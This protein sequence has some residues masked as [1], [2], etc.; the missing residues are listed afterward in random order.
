MN[1]QSPSSQQPGAPPEPIVP[2]K[3][4]VP[5]SPPS[6]SGLTQ[7]RYPPAQ[8]S[9][10][11]PS[12]QSSLSEGPDDQ[13]S[14]RNAVLSTAQR[15]KLTGYTEEQARRS[16]K[17]EGYSDEEINTAM[18]QAYPESVH[19]GGDPSG[20]ELRY[21]FVA[22][23]KE[24]LLHPTT[25]FEVV[26]EEEGYKPVI[27]YLAILGAII[28]L[29][30]IAVQAIT[31]S[32]GIV[33]NPGGIYTNISPETEVGTAGYICMAGMIPI[34]IGLLIGIS[35]VMSGIFHLSSLVFGAR[36]PFLQTY[37][38][39]VY[40]QTPSMIFS[41]LSSVLNFE[42]L[43]IFFSIWGYILMV[44]GLKSLQGLSTG[45]AIGTILIPVVLIGGCIFAATL[46][47][48]GSVVG[49]LGVLGM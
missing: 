31:E 19:S 49:A 23:L 42:F 28:V 16:L 44:I 46:L 2:S 34:V 25:F 47:M 15:K 3:A 18:G 38:A 48:F 27:M 39:I 26:K 17:E 29:L 9:S 13:G 6:S 8:I 33:I 20:G 5:L 10:R 12:T 22:K 11:Q 37:K 14:R 21:G 4:D 43:G 40:G 36:Q 1:V 7:N 24:V 30:Q 35:F 32:L 41:T 45:R